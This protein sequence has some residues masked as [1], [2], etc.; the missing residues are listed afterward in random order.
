MKNILPLVAGLVLL[1]GCRTIQISDFHSATPTPEPLPKLG[2]A[3]HTE[4]FALLFGREMA[5]DILIGNALD[6]GGY[7]PSPIGVFTQV[8]QPLHDVYVL[9]GNE[10]SD[11]IALGTGEQ[12]GKARFKLIYY[13]RYN[14][15]W[16][17]TIPSALTA[18]AVNIFGLPFAVTKSEVELQMEVTD[19]SGRVLSRYRA[20]GTGKTKVAMYYGY[21]GVG[22]L[23]KANLL[24][25]QDAMQGIKKQLAADLPQ[26]K[27]QLSQAG[28]DQ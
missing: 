18:F 6:P 11:N 14:S 4:S 7:F 8:G 25:L 24:A 9:L 26:L 17:Y 15:G 23:R 22:A 12:Q 10:L 28:P 5:E 2:L 1:A 20:P 19:N 3:V 13:N 16:G 27:E 21:S